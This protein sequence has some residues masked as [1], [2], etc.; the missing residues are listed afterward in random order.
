[1]RSPVRAATCPCPRCTLSA[2]RSSS[3]QLNEDVE[4]VTGR[5]P[6]HLLDVG[7]GFCGQLLVPSTPSAPMSPITVHIGPL[8]L[9][10]GVLL[11]FATSHPRAQI[12][13]TMREWTDLSRSNARTG[14]KDDG[15]TPNSTARERLAEPRGA[16]FYPSRP[17]RPSKTCC[18]RPDTVNALVVRTEQPAVRLRRCLRFLT[19]GRMMSTATLSLGPLPFMEEA[20]AHRPP[21]VSTCPPPPIRRLRSSSSRKPKPATRKRWMSSS[22]ATRPASGAGPTAG[23]PPPPGAR[24]TPRTSSR[25]R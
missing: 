24:S 23:C 1:M 7:P 8:F 15:G 11:P 25:T 3:V 18:C 12:R 14:P 6:F 5:D 21:V 2:G 22:P 9:P 13:A 10:D 17:S 4:R 20:D 16:A 19:V